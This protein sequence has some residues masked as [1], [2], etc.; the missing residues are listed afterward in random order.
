FVVHRQSRSAGV[1]MRVRRMQD[2]KSG[3]TWASRCE[4]QRITVRS[5]R[6]G[7]ERETAK[8][9]E[10]VTTAERYT[11]KEETSSLRK[12]WILSDPPASA[13]QPRMHR[14]LPG[15]YTGAMTIDA[16]GERL[17]CNRYDDDRDKLYVVDADARVLDS[18]EVPQKHRLILKAKCIPDA[19]IVL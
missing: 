13:G 9:F 19:G 15:P 1:P 11:Q 7:K 14:L 8:V 12:G 17:I 6:A 4:G 16:I 18:I 3:Q 2:P 5:I 10:D